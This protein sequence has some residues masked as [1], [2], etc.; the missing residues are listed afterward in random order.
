[1]TDDH[2]ARLIDAANLASAR[3]PPAVTDR[4]GFDPRLMSAERLLTLAGRC[5]LKL[6]R[7]GEVLSLDCADCGRAV[8]LLTDE[9]GEPWRTSPMQILTGALRHQVMRHELSLSGGN[10]G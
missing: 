3:R 6:G 9:R 1:M 5:A 10:N 4:L 7:N 2:A 8:D